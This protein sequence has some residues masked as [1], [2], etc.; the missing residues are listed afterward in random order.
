[1]DMPSTIM[2]LLRQ[3]NPERAHHL[4]L[5]AL[6]LGFGPSDPYSDQKSLAIKVAGLSFKNPIGLAAGF[7]KNA[8]VISP[9][10]KVGFGFVETGTVTPKP[11]EGNTRPRVFRLP[12]DEAIINRLGFNNQGL[13]AFT[14]RL[15]AHKINTGVVGANIGHNKISTDPISDYIICAQRVSP[16]CDYLTI[17]VS[18]PN[19]PGLRSLQSK[20]TLHYLIESV[21]KAMN[22]KSKPI[23]V[24]IAP[25]LTKE[26][27]TDIA[28][29]AVNSG[30][31]GLIVSNTTIER[32]ANIKNPLKTETGGLSG[33]PLLV[34]S[35]QLLS[36]MY[37]RTEG[38]I[39]LVGVGGITSG[40]D[41]YEKICAGASLVQLYTGLIYHGPKLV[42]R[43][44][45]DLAT[46][47]KQG[48]FSCIADAVGS[49]AK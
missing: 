11:Q 29:V 46:M 8:E 49:K 39:A 1:M 21:L 44:K 3:I 26:E 48:G 34:P 32:I 38:K 37:V 15:Q 14:K 16:F 27:R 35:T 47:L 13:P 5:L 9:M 36:E 24:K 20:D 2:P 31:A 10:L 6:K 18:S 28:D 4:T 33:K 30:I 45:D 23:F 12:E 40:S 22:K 42:R 41:A 7:D 25:D 17:N 19:T 43:I